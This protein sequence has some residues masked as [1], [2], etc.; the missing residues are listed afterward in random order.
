MEEEDKSSLLLCSLPLFYDPLVTTLVYRKET[1]YYE[2]IVSI[3]R[4]NEQRKKLTKEGVSQEGLAV[5]ERSKRGK[6]RSK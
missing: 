6:K 1:L 3:L 4:S 5:G 2:D